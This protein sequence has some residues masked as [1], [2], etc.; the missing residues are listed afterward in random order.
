MG[1]LF[2][3]G[4]DA[5][6]LIGLNDPEF[7]GELLR[8]GDSGDRHPRVPGHVEV[9]HA[10]DVHAVDVIGPEDGHHVRVGLLDEVDVLQD[11]VGRTLVPC[12]ALR[13][14]LRRHRDDEVGL[15]DSAELPSLAQMLEQRL[16]AELGEHVDRVDS[17]IDEIAEDEIDD[18]V[19][20]SEGNRRLGAFSSE[21]KQAGS[22]ATGE[23]NPQHADAQGT[24]HG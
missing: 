8:H 3:K 4:Q 15:Q 2:V 22:L 11:G 5:S 10:G 21:G 9:D 13:T 18:P 12:F 19:L 1:I 20:A 7:G 14:H 6:V 24:F 23:H 17:G 16:A